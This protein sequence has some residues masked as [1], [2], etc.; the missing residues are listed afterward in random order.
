[1]KMLAHRFVWS[2]EAKVHPWVS[3]IEQMPVHV[4]AASC[5]ICTASVSSPSNSWETVPRRSSTDD[6]GGLADIVEH[7]SPML[8]IFDPGALCRREDTGYRGRIHT[9]SQPTINIYREKR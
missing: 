4:Q 3:I 7:T 9:E 1:M 6:G 2:P 5:F 8:Q